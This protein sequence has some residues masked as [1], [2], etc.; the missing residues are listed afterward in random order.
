MRER[1]CITTIVVEDS[2]L[3]REGLIELLS[4]YPTIKIVGEAEHPDTALRLIKELKPELLFLDIHMPG[5]TGFD[6]LAQL[7]YDPLIIFTTAYS[8]YAIRSFEF[9]T[10]DYLLKPISEVRLTQSIEKLQSRLETSSLD[11]EAE[12]M[13]PDHRLFVKDKDECHI[14]SLAEILY[15]ESCK[16]YVRLFFGDQSA[17]IKK[18]LSQVEQRLPASHFFRCSRKHIINL[19][20]VA[21]IEESLNEGLIVT[22][23]GYKENSA[24]K[25]DVSRR[26]AVKLKQILSF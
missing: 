14:V 11:R 9:Q 6:L 12:R 10:I 4:A 1:N 5:Q 3:A 18:S 22:I 26:S 16:N 23:S 2:N 19:H 17:F 20:K 21:G 24:K 25:V 15:F 8:E 13:A 7:D